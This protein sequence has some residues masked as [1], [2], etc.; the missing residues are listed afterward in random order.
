MPALARLARILPNLEVL[1]ARG[2]LQ[3][4]AYL[5]SMASVEAQDELDQE[6]VLEASA[7]AKR[8]MG[9]CEAAKLASLHPG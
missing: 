6:R 7:A 9:A 5:L 4:L 8:T 3:F 1:A 2:G